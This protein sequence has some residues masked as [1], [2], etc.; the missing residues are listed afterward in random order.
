M[1]WGPEF[2]PATS[3]PFP[4]HRLPVIK[5]PKLPLFYNLDKMGF[6][7]NSAHPYRKVVS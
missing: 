5:V 2:V 4:V 7:F 3:L 1:D 6:A